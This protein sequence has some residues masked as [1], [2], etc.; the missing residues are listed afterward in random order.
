MSSDDN[1]QD[2]SDYNFASDGFRIA[3]TSSCN[4]TNL[5]PCHLMTCHQYA[6]GKRCKKI[7]CRSLGGLLQTDFRKVRSVIDLID[8]ALKIVK[9]L[10]ILTY[11]RLSNK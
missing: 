3:N 11:S 5:V 7:R 9:H 10:K 2:L 8:I 6:P 4:L 1:K